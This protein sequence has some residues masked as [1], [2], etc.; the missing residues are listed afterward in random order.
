MV[1]ALE[2]QDEVKWNAL[3]GASVVLDEADVLLR[4]QN[5]IKNTRLLV[6]LREVSRLVVGISASFTD[7]QRN[8][9]ENYL[10][11]H[12]DYKAPDKAIGEQEG[13]SNVIHI[14]MNEMCHG[15]V[16]SLLFSRNRSQ[17]LVPTELSLSFSLWMA[18]WMNRELRLLNL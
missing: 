18:P 10:G 12:I 9:I 5:V 17:K 2:G 13:K 14:P 8:F 3:R 1:E 7:N 11:D 16:A 6:K 4:A 15:R